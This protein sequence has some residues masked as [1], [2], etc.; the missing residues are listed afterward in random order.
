MALCRR[1]IRQDSNHLPK[2]DILWSQTLDLPIIKIEFDQFELIKMLL[3]LLYDLIK[4]M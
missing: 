4:N 3:L 2:V 1:P